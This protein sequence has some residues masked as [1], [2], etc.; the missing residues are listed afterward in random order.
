MAQTIPKKHKKQYYPLISAERRL[1]VWEKARGI[2]KS[3]KPE[4]IQE[5]KEM[6]SGWERKLPPL[7]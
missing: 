7:A 5:L 6:R 3:K 1:E 2:W 4:P